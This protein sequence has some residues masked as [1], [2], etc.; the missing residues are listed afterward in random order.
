MKIQLFCLKSETS[1]ESIEVECDIYLIK[2]LLQLCKPPFLFLM[3]FTSIRK[4]L[5]MIMCIIHW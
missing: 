5:Y 4:W 3:A 2:A 1:V